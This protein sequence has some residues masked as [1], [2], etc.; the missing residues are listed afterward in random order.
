MT[1]AKD[2]IGLAG[3]FA[4]ASELCKRDMYIQLTLGNKKRTDLLVEVG[5]NF[6][7]VEVKSK[8]EDMASGERNFERKF[9]V[10]LR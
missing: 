1:I 4:V 2:T 6:I 3:E 8:Q 9:L 7:K 10:S 5:D